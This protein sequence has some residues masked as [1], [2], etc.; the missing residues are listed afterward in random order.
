M[1]AAQALL[2]GNSS[3][4]RILREAFGWVRYSLVSSQLRKVLSTMFDEP[5]AELFYPV[6]SSLDLLSLDLIFSIGP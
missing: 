6:V 4:T 3:G 2:R 1:N 5:M